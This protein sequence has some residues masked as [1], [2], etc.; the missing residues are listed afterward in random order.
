MAVSCKTKCIA[1]ICVNKTI[2]TEIWEKTVSLMTEF[3]SG[4]GTEMHPFL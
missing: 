1:C 2:I 4:V 3:A